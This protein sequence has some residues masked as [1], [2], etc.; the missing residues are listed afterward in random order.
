MN[1]RQWDIIFHLFL[2]TSLLVISLL[3]FLYRRTGSLVVEENYHKNISYQSSDSSRRLYLEFSFSN[4]LY[5]YLE[6]D[7]AINIPIFPTIDKRTNRKYLLFNW[8]NYIGFNHT[9]NINNNTLAY[10]DLNIELEKLRDS[11]II[12]RY[13]FCFRFRDNCNN[14][15]LRQ[16]RGADDLNYY[17]DELSDLIENGIPGNRRYITYANDRVTYLNDDRI[18]VSSEIYVENDLIIGTT[19]GVVDTTFSYLRSRHDIFLKISGNLSD[20]LKIPDESE[21]IYN[22]VFDFH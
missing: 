6:G 17:V 21:L 20:T 10:S 2:G 8:P 1:S 4:G 18:C 3:L 22:G 5:N 9:K 15:S 13:D 16:A 14:S 11:S 7:M 12:Y 19:K